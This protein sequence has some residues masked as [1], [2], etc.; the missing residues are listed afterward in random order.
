MILADT[1][2][3]IRMIVS[4]KTEDSMRTMRDYMSLLEREY[5]QN[6]IKD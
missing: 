3:H 1:K 2:N 4:G 5:K 6:E